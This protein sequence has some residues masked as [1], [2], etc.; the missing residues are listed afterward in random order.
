M[1]RIAIGTLARG[2]DAAYRDDPFHALRRNVESVRPEEWDVRPSKWSEEVFGTDPEL[3]ICDIVTHVAGAKQ[4]YVDRIFGD[5]SLEWGDM[6]APGRDMETMLAWLDEG[7]RALAA[8]LAALPDDSM[9]LEERPAPWR[10]PLTVE[11]LIGIV[12]N[13]DVYH[14]GEVNRQRAL[15][16]GA[17]G[18]ERGG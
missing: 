2:L 5:A 6:R 11:Q 8:G 4:M 1:P 10:R 12:T 13:H 14:S 7:H 17:E 16:R 9:L 3:S 15:I 18:W